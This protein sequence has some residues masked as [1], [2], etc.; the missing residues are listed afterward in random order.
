M[1]SQRAY[2]SVAGPVV[3]GAAAMLLTW[4]ATG[5]ARSLAIR[6][7]IFD[8]PNHRS[9]HTSPTPRGGGAAIV[10]TVLLAVVVA[11]IAGWLALST[12]VALIG[13]GILVAFVGWL[14]DLHHVSAGWRA[15]AHLCAAAW[16]IA[17]LGG[18]ENVRLGHFGGISGPV[19]SIFAVIAIAW[20]INLYNFMD[21][22]DGIAA[23]ETIAVGASG[24]IILLLAGATGLAAVSASLAGAGAGFLVWNRMPARIFMGDV[25]SGFLGFAFAT[26]ALAAHKTAAIS[27]TVWV[28]LL[29]V[30]IADATIT[31]LRRIVHGDSWHVA[32]RL[33]AYQRLVQSG[34]THA[35]VVLYVAWL[36]L[37]LAGLA[38]V[39]FTKPAFA[40]PALL[41][42][43]L[44]VIVAYL[45]VER[46]LG[47]WSAAQA[48]DPVPLGDVD[49][50]R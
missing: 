27:A 4:W 25:G 20:L 13:G 41:A 47:M 8:V 5:F 2:I 39:V 11:A 19:A 32:H 48:A 36:D 1:M 9:S 31:L 50:R 14:D 44:V 42:A 10:L 35:R 12:A 40:W 46:R 15:I 23:V 38:L 24:A 21:G 28:I 3:I 17:W 34:C 22:I 18:I 16:A 33:H 43:V 29:L 30:F 6:R 26:L 37:L 45:A 7:A 49:R